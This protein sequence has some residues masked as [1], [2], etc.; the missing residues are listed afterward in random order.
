M[1]EQL[2]IVTDQ[3]K[4]LEKLNQELQNTYTHFERTYSDSNEKYQELT[5]IKLQLEKNLL[6]QQL[7]V[8]QEKNGKT[9]VLEKIHELEGNHSKRPLHFTD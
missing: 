3:N 4:R 7:L 2:H 8:E 9:A 5:T 1:N 6:E